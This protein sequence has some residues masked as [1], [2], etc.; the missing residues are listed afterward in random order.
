MP[1]A[2]FIAGWRH[3]RETDEVLRRSSADL[4]GYLG[5]FATENAKLKGLVANAAKDDVFFR[6]RVD[7]AAV[8]AAYESFDVLLLILGAGI[9][10][11]SGKVFE[12]MSSALPIVSVHDPG[13]A[14]STVLGGYP[15]WFPAADMSEPVDWRSAVRRAAA[16]SAVDEDTRRACVEI[17]ATFERDRQLRPRIEHLLTSCQET[18]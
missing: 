9:Y 7:K 3:A 16:A 11:T 14:A 4:W 17:A 8:V 6:G 13:N 12:Y 18:R 5:F 10:V 1:I 2:E 15:L